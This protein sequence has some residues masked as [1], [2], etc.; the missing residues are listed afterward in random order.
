MT[1]FILTLSALALAVITP[2]KAYADCDLDY[3]ICTKTCSVKHLTDEGSGAEA[4]CKTKCAGTK[5][6][7][8]VK[9]GADRTTEA[10]KNAWGNTKSFFD[11]LTKD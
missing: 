2:L 1:K 8:L 11:E 10:T 3:Q 7:C 5:A 6:A 4:G 9:V